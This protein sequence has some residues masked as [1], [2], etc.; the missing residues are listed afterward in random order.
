MHRAD[1]STNSIRRIAGRD[2]RGSSLKIDS[3]PTVENVATE[4]M[5]LVRARRRT[6]PLES[7]AFGL[8]RE[9]LVPVLV[10]EVVLGA[11]MVDDEAVVLDCVSTSVDVDVDSLAFS[12]S[13][14]FS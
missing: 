8:G 12:T 10:L 11:A 4:V 9:V 7:S 14:T 1:G 2:S 13:V 5:L 6:V 3:A